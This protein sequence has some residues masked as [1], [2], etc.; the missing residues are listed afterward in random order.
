M[1]KSSSAMKGQPMKGKPMKGKVMEGKP[2]KYAQ[3]VKGK[4]SVRT[5]KFAQSVKDMGKAK[6]AG[7]LI[8]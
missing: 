2:M 4:E 5:G 6:K 3:S 1:G 7:V 8:F